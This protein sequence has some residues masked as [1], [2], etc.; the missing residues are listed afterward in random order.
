MR[1]QRPVGID[2]KNNGG[3]VVE[4]FSVKSWGDLEKHLRSRGAGENAG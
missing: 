1:E 3:K 2:L 4:G